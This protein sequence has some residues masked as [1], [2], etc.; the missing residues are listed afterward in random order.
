[1][2][3]SDKSFSEFLDFQSG[4]CRRAVSESSHLSLEDR[5]ALANTYI[6]RLWGVR[7]L[8]IDFPKAFK[9]ADSAISDLQA[10]R[11]QLADV[12]RSSTQSA[13]AVE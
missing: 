4:F 10:F 5:R 11:N 8:V 9:Q 1:M 12:G 2:N 7:M 13:E 3:I 6:E